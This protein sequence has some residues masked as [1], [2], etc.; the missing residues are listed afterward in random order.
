[1]TFELILEDAKLMANISSIISSIVSESIMRISK[2]GISIKAYDTQKISLID[3]FMKSSAFEKYEVKEPMEVGLSLE[4]LN[5]IL[6][7]AGANESLKLTF[8]NE[9]K[10]FVIEFLS[11]KRRRRFALSLIS[12]EEEEGVPES[13]SLEFDVNFQVKA[14]FI[15]QVIKDAELIEEHM[16]ISA[17]AEGITFSASG[18]TNE[19]KTFIHPESDEIDT[20]SFVVNAESTADYSLELLSNFLK[21]IRSSDYVQI[22]FS[23]EKPIKITYFLDDK[24]HL[25]YLVAPRME[26][27]EVEEYE[28]YE[29]YEEDM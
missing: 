17:N 23:S 15:Q 20:E 10:R 14:S 24:G 26:D 4:M 22:S 9:E 8:D 18:D 25:I 11:S 12:I 5:T 7:T 3:F 27:Y 16:T 2:E 28:D 29:D 1:M 13:I 21:G 6:K 19:M